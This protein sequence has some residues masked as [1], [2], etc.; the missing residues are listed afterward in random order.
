MD[1]LRAEQGRA[2]RPGGGLALIGFAGLSHLGIVSSIAAAPKGWDVVAYDPDASLCEA[3][4]EGRLSLLELGLAELLVAS[5]SAANTLADLCEA[6]GAAEWSEIVPALRSDRRIGPYIYRSPGLGIA[7][8]N[9]VRDLAT[10]TGLVAEHGTD[11]GV[12]DAWISN[13]DH[14]CDWALE[15]IE[16]EVLVPGAQ[17]RIGVWGFAY[18]PL[19]PTRPG[20]H[21]S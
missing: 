3:L 17:A 21:L 7:G 8:G 11:A 19:A 4:A 12:V 5:I 15:T 2:L 14:R 20:T 16:F 10:V 18:K 1:Q 6:I 13:G 9:L